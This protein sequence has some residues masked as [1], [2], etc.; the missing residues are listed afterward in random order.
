VDE[1]GELVISIADTGI[2]MEPEFMPRLYDPFKQA[3]T[4]LDRKYE[5]TGLGLPLTKTMVKLH[6]GTLDIESCLGVGMNVTI[7]LPQERLVA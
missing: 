2:G 5:G 3:E 6:S 7:R 4:G 1:S